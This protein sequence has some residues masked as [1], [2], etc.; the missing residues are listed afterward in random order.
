MNDDAKGDCY[1]TAGIYM[2]DECMFR[3]KCDLLLVHAEVTGQG[4][5]E[6]LKYGHAFIIDGDEVIDKSN[7]NNIRMP[8]TAY[9]AEARIR[10]NY[11]IYNYDQFRQK[12]IEHQ[13]YGPWD[14]KTESGQ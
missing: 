3:I 9:F 4:P 13:H 11:H 10:N 14:L 6:G 1:P 2:M 12:I 5:I 8:R 7:G